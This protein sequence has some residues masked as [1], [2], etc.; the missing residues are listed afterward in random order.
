MINGFQYNES[1]LLLTLVTFDKDINVKPP[2]D[3]TPSV[4]C[5]YSQ[6]GPLTANTGSVVLHKSWPINHVGPLKP[7]GNV[8]VEA[9]G[10]SGS[11]RRLAGRAVKWPHC[12]PGT[13]V[14]GCMGQLRRFGGDCE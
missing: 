6:W 5:K 1:E 9:G 13:M 10:G 7:A 12:L 11:G 2:P 3:P 14:I 8:V 4:I